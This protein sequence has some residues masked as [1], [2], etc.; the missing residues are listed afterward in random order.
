MTFATPDHREQS[1]ST[2]GAASADRSLVFRAIQQDQDRAPQR[3]AGRM[4]WSTFSGGMILVGGVLLAGASQSSAQDGPVINVRQA[5]R[6]EDYSWIH[7]PPPPEPEKIMVHDIIM[8]E[9][10][11]KSEVIVNSRFNRQ[12][13]G[14]FK[15]QLSSFIR[16]G[17]DL[18]L[19]NVAANQPTIDGTLQNRLQTIGQATDQEGITYKIAATVVDVLPNGTLV[20]EARK[21]I[22][23]NQDHFEY[24]LSGKIDSR[25][26][27]PN[28]T[29]RSIH[30][31]DLQI[32]RTQRGK[33]FD[34]TKVNWG[35][36]VLD[37]V[38]P[39]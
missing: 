26:I 32:E 24:R 16:V 31:A 15:A 35:T 11:E 25:R 23:S 18:T 3:A 12:R 22:V 7:I 8:I 4:S 20:L 30:V 37:V 33:I 17:D 5:S 29:A 27:T 14:A 19:E 34:S 9:V 10:D 2:N 39:F 13:N 28:R 38:W 21:G 36:R 6:A 1:R